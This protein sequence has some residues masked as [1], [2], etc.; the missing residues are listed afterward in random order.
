MSRTIAT[1]TL[2]GREEMLDF[3]RPR[4][5]HLLITA[6]ADGT[7]QASPVTAGVDASGRIVLATYPER[8][9]ASNLRR[10]SAYSVLDWPTDF[11]RSQPSVQSTGVAP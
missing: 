8:A 11:W 6:R 10:D 7:P 2:V 5:H 1:T 3:V 4:H 9:K